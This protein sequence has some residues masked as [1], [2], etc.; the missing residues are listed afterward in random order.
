MPG[1]RNAPA[2]SISTPLGRLV[3]GLEVGGVG[4]PPAAAFVAGSVLLL[5]MF[6]AGLGPVD[7]WPIAVYPRF[8][9]RGGGLPRTSF[10]L[11]FIATPPGGAEK[12]LKSN[13]YP[14]GDTAAVFRIVRAALNAKKRNRQGELDAY[15]S[16]IARLVRENNAPMPSGTR[17]AVYQVNF[18]VDP[19]DRAYDSHRR[20]LVAETD[21]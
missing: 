1:I 14:F 13:F 3:F 7:S 21:L 5:G 16:L 9:D 11:V 6:V 12:E 18:S 19:S 20:V 4:M 8:S 15:M 10:S 17:L 2:P